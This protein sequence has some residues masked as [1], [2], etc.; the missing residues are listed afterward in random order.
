ILDALEDGERKLL[1]PFCDNDIFLRSGIETDTKICM[2]DSGES[3]RDE[4][5]DMAITEYTYK[6]AKC[7]KD[8]TEVEL[9]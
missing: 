6:C 8:T 2:Y 9:K 4:D 3:L 7:K 5:I 1:C